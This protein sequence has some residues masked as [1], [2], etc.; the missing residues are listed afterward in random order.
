[1]IAAVQKRGLFKFTPTFSKCVIAIALHWF[2]SWKNSLHFKD[3]LPHSDIYSNFRSSP[4]H[5]NKFRSKFEKFLSHNSLH[6]EREF[7]MVW[8]YMVSISTWKI[9]KPLFNPFA[10]FE[11]IHSVTMN[12][13]SGKCKN[14]VTHFFQVWRN[15]CGVI[16]CVCEKTD[17]F[18]TAFINF[19][20]TSSK[21]SSQICDNLQLPVH[22]FLDFFILKFQKK[23]FYIKRI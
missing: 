3:R 4:M 16:L 9:N 18:F 23:Y 19:K 12:N 20:V 11:H 17:V 10:N 22:C 1:M 13:I 6:I 14:R 21:P 7:L 15:Q 2:S 8:N 5:A